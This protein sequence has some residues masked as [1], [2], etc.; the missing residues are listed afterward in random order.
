MRLTRD[1]TQ[2]AKSDTGKQVVQVTV[3]KADADAEQADALLV[4]TVGAIG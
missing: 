1:S 2:V 3:P 4:A